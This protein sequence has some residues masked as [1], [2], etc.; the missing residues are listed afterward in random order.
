MNFGQKYPGSGSSLTRSNNVIKDTAD[1]QTFYPFSR[2]SN[3][4][5][6]KTNPFLPNPQSIIQKFI[7]NYIIKISLN[8]PLFFNDFLGKKKK[9]I[10]VAISSSVTIIMRKF[11]IDFFSCSTMLYKNAGRILFGARKIK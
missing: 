1:F 5:L 2:F 7:K 11:S 6:T 4:P 9:K 8:F 3:F 10:F